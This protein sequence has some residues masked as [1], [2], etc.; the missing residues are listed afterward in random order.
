[1]ASKQ[2]IEG[3]WALWWNCGIAPPAELSGAPARAEWATRLVGVEDQDLVTAT[4]AIARSASVWPT[5]DHTVEMAWR[6]AHT[7]GACDRLDAPPSVVRAV[8]E[9][10]VGEAWGGSV[11]VLPMLAWFAPGGV[12]VWSW[13]VVATE[14]GGAATRCALGRSDV[15]ALCRALV[16]APQVAGGTMADVLAGRTWRRDGGGK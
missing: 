13:E 5:I 12:E 10:L 7:R 2:A 3:A 8:L 1:M 16:A 6:A 11:D 9:R 4:V 15:E 14:A